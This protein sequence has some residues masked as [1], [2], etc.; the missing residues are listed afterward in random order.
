MAH[1]AK[2]TA[3]VSGHMCNH[4]ARSADPE[5]SV[6]RK[7]ENIDP[8]RTHLN[9]NLAA[10]TQ[11]LP[12]VEFIRQRV[13]E[14]KHIRRSDV[15]VLCDWVVTL[16]KEIA[17]KDSP[18]F[19][20][21]AYDFLEEKYGEDNVVSAW[22]HMDEKQPHIHF[23]FV[24]VVWSKDRKTG[25][26]IEKLS[27]K[28]CV[29]KFDLQ[30]FHEKLENYICSHAIVC[31]LQ[32]GV[33][34]EGNKS[35]KELKRETA[36]QELRKIENKTLEAKKEYKS[37]L[38]AVKELRGEMRGLRGDIAELDGQIRDLENGFNELGREFQDKEHELRE[39]SDK[40]E[41]KSEV[42][43]KLVGRV[44]DLSLARF[45][46]EAEAKLQSDSHEPAKSKGFELEL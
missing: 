29:T 26:D 20:Q 31:N 32:N 41:V 23:A 7:N 38:E 2:F 25:E 14:V 19:F 35:I 45:E 39:L 30:S 18:E 24:P 37:T 15:N 9:Y 43:R 3:A 10:A 34:K 16:P 46:A 8:N 40:I 13:S 44:A 5:K 36:I 4:Y 6:I 11:P 33:T 22:V 17:W 28:E 42:Y 21:A 1:V 12:Q 27:A